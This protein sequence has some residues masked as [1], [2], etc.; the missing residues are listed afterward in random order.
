MSWKESVI[1][2]LGGMTRADVDGRIQ[3]ALSQFP[4]LA[5]IDPDE[6]KYRRLSL[7]PTRDLNPLAQDRMIQ[8]AHFLYEINPLAGSLMDLTRDF[9]VGEGIRIEGTHPDVDAVIKRHWDDPANEWELRLENKVLELGLYGEQCWP[10]FVSDN[11]GRVRLG[12]IDPAMISEVV[13][14][15][16]NVEMLIGIRLKSMGGRAG[17]QYRTILDAGEA[18]ILSRPARALRNQFGDG[19]AFLFQINRVSN[20]TRGRS[21]LLSLIDWLDAYEGMMFGAMENTDFLTSFIWDVT[22]DGMTE[23]QIR[24]YAKKQRPPR[25]G[26]ARYHNERVHWNA[27]TPDLKSYEIAK[28]ARTFLAHI[29]M[30]RGF[31]VHWLS[32]AEDVNVATAKEMGIPTIKRLTS[33]QKNV[34][35]V[36]R[37]VIRFV[38]RRAVDAG[39]LAPELPVLDAQGQETD[40]RKAADECFRIVAPELSVR[41]MGSITTALSQLATALTLAVSQGL[42]SKETGTRLLSALGS[43]LGVEIEAEAELDRAAQDQRVTKDYEDPEKVRRI[44]DA[45]RRAAGSGQQAEGAES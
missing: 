16:E 45:M 5:G 1:R 30:R 10:A 23:E 36:L 33:R 41:D 4:S 39:V 38:V 25:R 27:V 11:M 9:V 31:P 17:K 43:M 34:V 12:Y 18:D 19:Q 6:D 13:P 7:Q 44:G 29:A 2:K 3:E 20:A 15:P 37:K 42:L 40:T 28:H 26:S 32:T 35:A 22:L 8:I 14:D 24:E 21:D